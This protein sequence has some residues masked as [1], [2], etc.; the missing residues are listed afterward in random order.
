MTEIESR[1]DAISLLLNRA[2]NYNKQS[3]MGTKDVD[4]ENSTRNTHITEH[5]HSPATRRE[6]TAQELSV[7]G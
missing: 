6:G 4:T 3:H 1:F 7:L 2:A 5:R